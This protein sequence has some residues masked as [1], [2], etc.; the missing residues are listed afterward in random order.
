[1]AAIRAV[2]VIGAKWAN[3]TPARAAEYTAGV[4]SPRASWSREAQAAQG[5]WEAG[6]QASIAAKSFSKGVAK[7][8]DAAWTRGAVEKGASRFGPGVQVAQADYVKGFTPYRNAIAAVSL[9][10][11]FARRDPR[12][13][14]RVQ[15]IVDAMVA[16]RK[17][18]VG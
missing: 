16:T 10:P 12:N 8:G 5:S 7:A 6:V 13:L 15:S 1:M 3:V 18:Q 17:S 14:L 11:R 9:P 4:Q 2:D